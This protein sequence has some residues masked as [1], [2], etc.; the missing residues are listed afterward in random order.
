MS[1]R[2]AILLAIGMLVLGVLLGALGGGVAGFV[3]GQNDR[4]MT[5]QNF[6]PFQVP[7][8][9]NQPN[10]PSQPNQ[11][12]QG[13]PRQRVF[14]PAQNVIG[15]ARVTEIETNS[16]AQKAGLQVGDVITA[17]GS[18]KLTTQ[19]ALADAIKNY[20]PG[21]KVD[22]SI[23]RGTQTI[24]ISVQLGTSTDNTNTA[25]LGIRYAPVV[26]NSRFTAPNE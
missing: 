26:P 19:T 7:Q 1:T 22:L 20:K 15:G 16:P 24:T 17:V 6:N 10:Q 25:W 2:G 18:T 4:F 3:A 12:N 5:R 8:Q 11:P 9:P 13:Q 14:P 23:T 21:D